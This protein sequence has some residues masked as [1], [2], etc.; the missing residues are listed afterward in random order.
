MGGLIFC[1]FIEKLC[2]LGEFVFLQKPER[3]LETGVA[4]LR[5]LRD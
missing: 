3:F 2:R 4:R 5:A 1:N